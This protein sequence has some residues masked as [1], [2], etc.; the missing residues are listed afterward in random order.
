M[1]T[2]KLNILGDKVIVRKTTDGGN[3]GGGNEGGSGFVLEP[4]GWCWKLSD[5]LLAKGHSKV[6]SILSQ[7]FIS[8]G[9]IY[10]GIYQST[11]QGTTITMR[12]DDRGTYRNIAFL[13]GGTNIDVIA[14]REAKGAKLKQSASNIYEGDST[15][16]IFRQ[17][18][19]FSEEQFVANMANQGLIRITNEEYEA[20]T[21]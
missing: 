20:L 15:Y 1:N 12:E 8:L 17:I 6:Y 5:E 11:L 14:I 7:F 4:N 18:Q 21:A 3:E 9:R 19:G 16:D 13:S 10:D 2:I